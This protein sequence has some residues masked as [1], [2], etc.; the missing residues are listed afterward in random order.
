[1]KKTITRPF[2]ALFLIALVAATCVALPFVGCASEQAKYRVSD[3]CGCQR[4]PCNPKADPDEVPVEKKRGDE[5]NAHSG[6]EAKKTD[7]SES[8]GETP[9]P[10]SERTVRVAVVS[11]Q[12]SRPVTG[13]TCSIGESIGATD[14]SG[15]VVLTVPRTETVLRVGADSYYTRDVRL[16]LDLE[17]IRVPLL[18]LE[19]TGLV[20]GSDGVPVGQARIEIRISE[21][22]PLNAG[23]DRD[24]R[25]VVTQS[26]ANG[27]FGFPVRSQSQIAEAISGG[28]GAAVGLA[29]LSPGS[30]MVTIILGKGA[31]VR[32][33]TN[34]QMNGSAVLRVSGRQDVR[35]M[36]QAIVDGQALLD[37]V[38]PHSRVELTLTCFPM[39]SIPVTAPGAGDT[40]TVPVFPAGGMVEL[41]VVA[42]AGTVPVFSA[43]ALSDDGV[44]FAL[45]GRKVSAT[46][47]ALP[48]YL[49]PVSPKSWF[50]LLNDS[51]HLLATAT[52]D[53]VTLTSDAEGV[54]AVQPLVVRTGVV[55]GRDDLPV[56]D[57]EI[58]LRATKAFARPVVRCVSGVDGAFVISLPEGIPYRA[59]AQTNDSIGVVDTIPVSGNIVIRLG[60]AQ[61]ATLLI[62]D[63][64]RRYEYSVCATPA[65]VRT[66]TK[67]V[68]G[69]E[70]FTLHVTE[71][72]DGVMVTGHRAEYWFPASA[73]S[74][75]GVIQLPTDL[76]S[77]AKV[78]VTEGG[79]GAAGEYVPR[80][81]VI[82]RA[83][84]GSMAKAR[85]TKSRYVAARSQT[86]EDGFALIANCPGGPL[87]FSVETF[88]GEVLLESAS[89][90]PGRD[91]VY[92]IVLSAPRVGLV[93]AW[94]TCTGIPQSAT[95]SIS[96]LQ[97]KE[98]VKDGLSARG[99]RDLGIP[100]RFVADLAQFPGSVRGSFHPDFIYLY[101]RLGQEYYYAGML[102]KEGNEWR[103]NLAR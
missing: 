32:V 41:D 7:V 42:T 25:T 65:A 10:S 101:V 8:D 12:T 54:L 16:P 6:R 45:V 30:T 84:S 13:A 1:M 103:A 67:S 99:M 68:T 23:V 21:R 81:G 43:P 85:Q 78:R 66:R 22:D 11:Y 97:T 87:I 57:C 96:V 29:T 59:T 92:L 35:A 70:R 5:P 91:G 61:S 33:L 69:G 60:P 39:L 74:S 14:Q 77:S 26:D 49:F 19:G 15:E 75:D 79:C 52:Y 80:K 72:F 63:S 53:K 3:S 24:L 46:R 27:H 51:G 58:A 89:M 2:A 95:S 88:D 38:V 102:T 82:V 36:S 31:S 17:L 18:Q 64:G 71:L 48:S 62:D 28:E 93:E 100:L 86:D 4:N 55:L 44:T 90:D 40:I 20:V 56:G 47:I 50:G 98:K 9:P 83:A 76:T 73:I 37:G 34:S 94:G